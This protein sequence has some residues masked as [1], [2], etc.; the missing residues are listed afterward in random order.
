MLGI[1]L[2]KFRKTPTEKRRELLNEFDEAMED[3]KSENP[4][5]KALEKW[6]SNILAE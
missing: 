1:I 2:Q 4:S 5:T 3:V 6:I